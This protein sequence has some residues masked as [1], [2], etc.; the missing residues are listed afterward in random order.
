MYL[1]VHRSARVVERTARA[2]HVAHV[3]RAN[4]AVTKEANNHEFDH[5]RN[6]VCTGMAAAALVRNVIW[7]FTGRFLQQQQRSAS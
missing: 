4:H 1:L 2:S 6:A 5:N 3:T 7:I